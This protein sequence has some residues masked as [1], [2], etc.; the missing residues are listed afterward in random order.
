MTATPAHAGAWQEWIALAI[1]ALSALWLLRGFF[2][3]QVAG[4]LSQALLK[5]GRVKLAMKL[6]AQDS[7]GACSGCGPAGNCPAQLDTKTT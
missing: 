5:R 3:E 4:P 7:G 1:V 6:K 2:R